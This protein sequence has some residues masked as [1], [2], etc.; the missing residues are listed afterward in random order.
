MTFVAMSDHNSTAYQATKPLLGV[1]YDYYIT[2]YESNVTIGLGI[3]PYAHSP[4]AIQVARQS[5]VVN[6]APA[7][8][9]IIVWTN[10]TFGVS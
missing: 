6:G 10:K 2:I 1:G 9:Q 3:P 4:T 7:Q 5:V 8:M